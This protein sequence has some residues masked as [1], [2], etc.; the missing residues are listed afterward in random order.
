MKVSNKHRIWYDHDTKQI[1]GY[2]MDYNDNKVVSFPGSQI[3][4]VDDTTV[5]AMKDASPFDF[6]YDPD[7]S[8]AVPKPKFILVPDKMEAVVGGEVITV[9]IKLVNTI[10]DVLTWSKVQVKDIAERAQISSAEVSY[11]DGSFRIRSFVPGV[12]EINVKEVWDGVSRI[13]CTGGKLFHYAQAD[14][15]KVKFVNGGF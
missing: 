7:L 11:S 5:A 4:D 12:A 2:D 6:L 13:K 10:G 3:K 14:I 15:L 8:M 1:V 9:A